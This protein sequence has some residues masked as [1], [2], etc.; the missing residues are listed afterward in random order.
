MGRKFP[1]RISKAGPHKPTSS[2]AGSEGNTSWR[3]RNMI[4]R[5]RD[6]SRMYWEN[7][8]G[9]GDLSEDVDMVALTGTLAFTAITDTNDGTLVTGTG[10]LFLTQCHLGQFILGIKDSQSWLIVVRRVISDTEMVVWRAPDI[11]I[12]GVKGW[13]LAVLFA[14]NDQRGTCLRGNALKSDKGNFLSVGDGVFR[15]DGATLPGSSLTMTRAPQLSLLDPATGNYTNFTLGMGEPPAPTL[16]AVGGGTKGMQAGSYSLVTA[17]GRK[18]TGGYN[19]PSPR[20]DVTIAAGDRIEITF[21]PMDTATGQNTWPVWVTTFADTLGADLNYLNGPWHYYIEVDDTMVN[22]AGGTFII[23]YLDA[24]VETNE[25]VSFNNDPPTDAEFVAYLNN[26]P[27]LI[28]CQGQGNTVNPVATSPGPFICPAKPN[29]IEA[30]PL[31][32]AFSSS[33]PETILGVVSAQGRLYL[34]TI[35]HLQI[36]QS[37]P[38]PDVPILIRPFWHDGFANPYQ[39][40]FVNG[41][42]YGFP[43][44]GPS[45]SAGDGDPQEAQ[46]DWAE[47]VAEFTL[48]DDTASNPGWN[49]GHALVGY[50]PYNDGVV[51]FHS[52]HRLNA[53]GYWTT[54][55]LMFG[56]SKNDWIGDGEFSENDQDQI[57]SGV[58]T[59]GDRL[60]L[61]IGGAGWVYV[62][63]YPCLCRFWITGNSMV[64]NWGG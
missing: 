24:E 38:N 37:T 10:T 55:W 27:V 16:A 64:G 1:P 56:I 39:V 58:A 52:A 48:G 3:M 62:A 43:V 4:L 61:I 51:F 57:V 47:D 30:F 23:E 40:V 42:L 28:S 34:L 17:R 26:A 22:P 25:I 46:R 12:S 7:F 6:E 45:R 49:P 32:L 35:N 8:T 50:D 19:N 18:E 20:A 53:A 11:T 13:R 14:V 33:P 41:D 21:G 63:G 60:E 36:A 59:V 15:I 29:N 44:A 2:R 31:D 5:G 54:R 9:L